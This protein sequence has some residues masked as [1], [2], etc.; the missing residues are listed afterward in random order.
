MIDF[1]NLLQFNP[2]W[3]KDLMPKNLLGKYKRPLLTTMESYIKKRFIILIYGL[4]R[5][6]KTTILYQIINNLLENK[7]KPTNILYFSFDDKS[8]DLNEVID[9]YEEK[10][11]KKKIIDSGKLYVFFDEIQK[12]TDWQNKIK[13]LYDLNPDLKFFLSGSASVS[14]QKQSKESLAGRIIDFQLNPLS[15]REFIEWRE[16]NIDFHRLDFFAS[17]LKPLFIDFLRKG[18]F[19]E[20]INEEEDE[21]IRLYL[22]NTVIE[23]I[24]FQDLPQEFGI[25]DFELLRTLIEM[26]SREPGMIINAERLARDLGRTKVTIL[27]Y[28]YYL[29][30][31]L[32]IREVKNLRA[33]FLVASRKNKKIYPT[34]S[35]FGFVFDPDFYSQ[36]S[37]EKIAELVVA[38]KINAEYYYRN[39]FEVDFLQ[40]VDNKILPIEVKYGAVD[41][42]QVSDFLNKFNFK[43]GLIISKDTFSH[44]NKHGIKTIPLWMFLLQ[45]QSAA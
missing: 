1:D 21:K 16:I 17:T 39:G 38:E 23:R 26:F 30:Y 42:K 32:L 20:I 11:L 3:A 41:Q 12:V 6:G 29:R 22:K 45:E 40:K 8:V 18:G 2:W 9:L 24:V 37:L 15:F 4:R 34:S 31:S 14:L 35:A 19:P 33:N 43:E 10:V 27:N 13:F 44:K 28:L 25:K 7:I 36:K 5:T